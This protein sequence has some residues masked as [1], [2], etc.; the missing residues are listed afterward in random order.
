LLGS[1][2]STITAGGGAAT[3]SVGSLLVIEKVNSETKPNGHFP[4][5]INQGKDWF[6]GEKLC[7]NI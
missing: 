6:A 7:L 5:S 3:M 4:A 2:I 1:S